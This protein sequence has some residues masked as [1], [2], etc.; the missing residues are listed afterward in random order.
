MLPDVQ[1]QIQQSQQ[2][3]ATANQQLSTGLRVNQLSDD[4]AASASMV[5]TLAQSA[6]VDQFTSNVSILSSRMQTADSAISTMVSALQ[7]AITIGTAGAN[8][9]NTA[10]QRQGDAD[11]IAS[12]LAGVVAQANTKF[13]GAYIFGGSANQVPPLAQ[14]STS[15]ASTA[16]TLAALTPL[17]AGSTTTISD[18]STGQTFTFNAVAGDTVQTLE[19]AV[20]SA[21]STGVLSAGTTATINSTGQFEIATNNPNAGIVASSNDT[22]FGGMNAVSGTTVPNAYAYVGNSSVNHVQVG[23]SLSVPVNLPGSQFLT[24]GASVITAL[25]NLI[26]E[27]QSGTTATIGNAVNA[28]NAALNNLDT[29]RVPIGNTINRLNAQENFLSQEHVNLTS[30]QS[31]LVGINLAEAATNLSNAQMGN[32]TVLAAAAKALPQTLLDYLR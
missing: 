32:S 24:S 18:A 25:S 7:S 12:I 17:T 10:G 30:Q 8:G 26:T 4:P 29:V 22:V 2:N 15:F 16:S 3:L 5:R 23:D 1:Y 13:E 6:N 21:A 28:V 19:N 11:Q 9:I 20:A 14:A 27:L 31:A